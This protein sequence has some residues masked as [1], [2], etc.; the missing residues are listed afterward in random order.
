MERLVLQQVQKRFGP[1]VEILQGVSYTFE[2]GRFYGIIGASGAGKTTLLQIMGTLEEPTGGRVVINGRDSGEMS[3]QER[4][5]LRNEQIGFVFQSFYL[6]AYL[7]A[8]E[9]VMMPMLIT[10]VDFDDCRKRAEKLLEQMGLGERLE[11][12]PAQLSGGEQQRV[13]LVRALANRP[14]IILADE[15][16][17]N[18]DEANEDN[19]M[20][21]LRK[22]ADEGMTVIMVTHNQ[23]LL[24][25]VDRILRLA[26]GQLKSIGG[27]GYV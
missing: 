5:K 18:L 7:T 9:N 6:N 16:T 20:G 2:A 23:R 1:R 25:Q 13:A 12:Y 17:G 15:P 8:V 26:D 22:L 27:D 19:V 4:A 3:V 21:I 24:Q 10:K 14:N 11:H